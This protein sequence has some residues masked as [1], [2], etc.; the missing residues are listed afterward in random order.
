MAAIMSKGRWVN[1][2]TNDL[3]V[4]MFFISDLD[5]GLA[6]KGAMLMPKSIMTKVSGT[7]KRQ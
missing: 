1:E 6:S 3:H 2:M 4:N 7:M 5:I